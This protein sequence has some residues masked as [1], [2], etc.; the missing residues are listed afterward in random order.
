MDVRNAVLQSPDLVNIILRF[1]VDGSGA[2]RDPLRNMSEV[3]ADRTFFPLFKE[4]ARFLKPK[5][6]SKN[7]HLH[8][9]SFPSCH[10]PR[11]I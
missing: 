8:P 9:F 4:H 10:R 3:G 7:V 5:P 2:S 11:T 1:L 6:E